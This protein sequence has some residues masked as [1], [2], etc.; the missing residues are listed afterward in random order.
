MA[1]YLVKARVAR[2]LE[3]GTCP[4][5]LT[6]GMEF[7]LTA[8]APLPC[9]S[10]RNALQPAYWVLQF[11]G[12]FPWQSDPDSMELCC[13]DPANPVVFEVRRAPVAE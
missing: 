10:A 3:K 9:A 7:D 12:A 2:I 1:G 11:G 8:G 13:P 5:G 4:Q 6:P